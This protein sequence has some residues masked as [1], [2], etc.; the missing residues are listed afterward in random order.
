[1]VD[2]D[3]T[4]FNRELMAMADLAEDLTA[5]IIRKACIDLYRRL[6]ELT[7]VDTGRAKGS[8]A[9]STQ[10][11]TEYELPDDPE[12]YSVNEIMSTINTQVDEF[13]TEIIRGQVVIYNNLE[14]IESLE[15]GSSKQAPTGMVAVSLT[16]FENFFNQAIA[17]LGGNIT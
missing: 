11:D 16:E 15:Q 10:D 4:G 7:P 1:M 14:Y 9:L 12:G 6:V 5:E 17:K 8:W 2:V 3:A 13:S